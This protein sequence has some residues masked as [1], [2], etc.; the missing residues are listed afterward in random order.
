MEFIDGVGFWEFDEYFKK[1][2]TMTDLP[3]YEVTVNSIQGTK[4]V[5]SYG[6]SGPCFL[7]ALAGLIDLAF[8]EATW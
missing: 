1:Y 6:P 7:W 5:V 2:E 3:S 8:H 4:R